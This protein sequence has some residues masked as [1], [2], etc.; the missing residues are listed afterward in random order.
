MRVVEQTYFT[1]TAAILLKRQG[2]KGP[3]VYSPRHCSR[4]VE[5]QDTRTRDQDTFA[6]DLRQ[7]S[8]AIH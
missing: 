4:E 1:K 3:L 2:D 8:T 7:V 5:Q 6:F